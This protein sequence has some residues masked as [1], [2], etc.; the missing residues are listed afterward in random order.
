M[1]RHHDALGRPHRPASVLHRRRR[2]PGP[3]RRDAAQA[4]LC[5]VEQRLA[6]FLDTAAGRKLGSPALAQALLAHNEML[7][8]Q[9]DAFV[10]MDYP[11]DRRAE[12]VVDDPGAVA[13]TSRRSSVLTGGSKTSR[14]ITDRVAPAAQEVVVGS[15]VRVAN[16]RS[17][18]RRRAGAVRGVARRPR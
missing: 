4:A 12:P 15:G 9:V 8:R 2:R 14:S 6:G 11:H 17:R 3:G 13:P 16:T 18:W 10:A 5:D 1:H 7:L